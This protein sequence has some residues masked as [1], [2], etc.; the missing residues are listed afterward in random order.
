MLVARLNECQLSYIFRVMLCFLVQ[1]PLSSE[2]W[3]DWIRDECEQRGWS[4]HQGE[5][6]VWRE[7]VM[8]GGRGVY[9]GGV[10]EFEE[11]AAE[12]HDIS[13]PTSQDQEDNIGEC[14]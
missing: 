6:L 2:E 12:Y 8:R 3:P 10:K 9:L 1:I 13:P 14:G 11:Y 7:L 5:V 4:A